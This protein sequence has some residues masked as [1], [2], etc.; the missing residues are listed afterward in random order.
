MAYKLALVSVGTI[1]RTQHIPSIEGSDRFELVA[2]VSRNAQVEGVPTHVTQA[3]MLA[4]HPEVEVVSLC[5]PPAARF[6]YAAEAIAAGRHV[7]MEKPPGATVAECFELRRLADAAGVTIFATWHSREAAQV[8]AAR[9]W[10]KDRTLT[11]LRITWKE[12]VRHW[13]P[14][15]EWIWQPGGLGVFDPGINALS[16]LTAILP[17]PVHVEKAVLEFPANKGT[18][19]AA[20]LSFRHPAGA[21]VSAVFDW[22]QTGPQTWDIDV[23]TDAGTLGLSKGGAE[24]RID[25]ALVETAG[26]A[27]YPRLYARMADLIDRGESDTDYGPMIHVADAFALGERRVVAAFED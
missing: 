25:G 21:E 17:D 3:A 15:Q 9:D 6:D 26:D 24:L 4:A 16:I 5:M 7:M 12:D 18:P 11:S 10:L 19:I 22:R 1:A 2:A 8:D 20:R 13:H 23:E 27:E 14:G